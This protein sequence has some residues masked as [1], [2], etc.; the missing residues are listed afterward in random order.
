MNDEADSDSEAFMKQHGGRPLDLDKCNIASHLASHV[1]ESLAR[2]HR[3]LPLSET[4]SILRVA[5]ADPFDIDMLAGRRR[6]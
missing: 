1:P 4:A 3:V 2:K 5:M 6:W